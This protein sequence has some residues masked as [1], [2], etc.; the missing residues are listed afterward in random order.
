MALTRAQWTRGWQLTA[1]LAFCVTLAWLTVDLVAHAERHAAWTA[2]RAQLGTTRYD[3]SR[4]DQLYDAVFETRDA[5]RRDATILGIVCIALALVAPVAPRRTRAKSSAPRR[6]AGML[7][8]GALLALI[9]AALALGADTADR[10]GSEALAAVLGRLVVPLSIAVLAL[11][12][13]RGVAPS[14]LLRARS[15]PATRAPASAAQPKSNAP[16]E[17]SPGDR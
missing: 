8:D 5:L 1:L 7:G 4:S 9:G 15:V 14:M 10:R 2:V 6:L 11:A 17:K 3:A 16:V 12:L 13:R